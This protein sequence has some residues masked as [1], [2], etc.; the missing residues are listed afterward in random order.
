MTIDRYST[1]TTQC[2]HC[3]GTG[4]VLQPHEDYDCDG[5][6]MTIDLGYAC[7]NCNGEGRIA[8]YGWPE[9]SSNLSPDQPEPGGMDW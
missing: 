5:N 7:W 6:P 2:R 9:R 4:H 1:Y 3:N 8:K